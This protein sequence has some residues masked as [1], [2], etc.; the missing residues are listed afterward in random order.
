ML[1]CQDCHWIVWSTSGL[2]AQCHHP[3][4]AYTSTD[5]VDSRLR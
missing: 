3:Q 4:A 5:P 1:L 2:P